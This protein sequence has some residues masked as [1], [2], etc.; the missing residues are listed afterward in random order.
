MTAGKEMQTSVTKW[1][2]GQGV[3]IS[4][5]VLSDTGIQLNEPL[6]L[7][8]QNGRIILEKT[9]QKKSLEERAK[10]FGGK[11]GPYEE[12]SWGEPEGREVW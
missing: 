8:V 2:N 7:I 12:F 10:E 4:K 6:N 1:G 9:Y 3:R 11:L 5:S